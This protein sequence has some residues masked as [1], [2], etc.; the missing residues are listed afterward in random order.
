MDSVGEILPLA[1]RCV[2]AG[3]QVRVW[4]SPDNHGETGKGFKGVERVSNWLG[5]VKWADIVIP[6]GNH[7]F[8]PKLDSLRKM[9]IKVFG[10]SVAS[11]N[12]E[13]KRAEGMKFFTDHGIEVPEWKQFA[14]L[15]AA[16]THVRKTNERYVFKTLGDEDDKSLS[17]VG[18]SPA[19]MIARLQRWQ[20]LKMNP[21]GPVMLQ[22]VIDGIEFAVSRWMGKEGFIG[23]ANIN[24]EFKKLLSGD[25]GPNCGESGTIMQYVHESK[26][27]DEVL[28]PLEDDLVKMGH[29]GD[30]D[31]NCIIDEKGK[32]WPLE[33]TMRLGW[34]AFNIMLATHKGDPVQWMLDACNGVDSLVTSPAVAC[35]IVLA[36]PDYPNSKLTKAE[37][38]NIPI[39]G[40]NSD[41]KKF[42]APQSVKIDR[43]PDMDGD[44]VVERDIWCTTGDYIAV[45]TG[46]GKTVKRATERAYQTIK[47]LHVP[48]LMYRDDIGE[49]L[50]DQIPKLQK[51]GYAMD[52][53]YGT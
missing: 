21:K 30:I 7:D 52:I 23:Q 13:I 25:C 16:E 26:L 29:L 38:A 41:N 17:Y 4:F 53:N 44:T 43:M 3:H 10:P 24:W 40:V 33:F 6:S 51:H 20:D 14:D 19:D 32:A 15:K 46:L 11:A 1:I 2:K 34:P 22:E 9:G 8:M 47:E 48:N 5:S 18:K 12:L 39:Y 36:Q 31:V 37:L 45:V 27:A 35:G 42:I 50:K 28:L 49:K